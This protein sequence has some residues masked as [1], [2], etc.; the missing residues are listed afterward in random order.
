MHVDA[1]D[2]FLPPI[3]TSPGPGSSPGAMAEYLRSLVQKRIIMPIICGTYMMAAVGCGR[4]SHWFHT[5][6]VPRVERTRSGVQ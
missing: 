3:G 5:I 1:M 6:I 4:R 2:Q